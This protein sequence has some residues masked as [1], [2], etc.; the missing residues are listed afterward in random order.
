MPEDI[1]GKAPVSGPGIGLDMGVSFM[2]MPLDDQK[3][4][5]AQMEAVVLS[6][7]LCQ[8]DLQYVSAWLLPCQ[9]LICKDCFQGLMQELGQ[10][11]Q[12]HG[13]VPEGKYKNRMG[14]PPSI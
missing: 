11:A 13:T 14:S 12:D 3:H 4:S 1:N 10:V 5:S 7:L 6:C 8:Q 2:G 9:H